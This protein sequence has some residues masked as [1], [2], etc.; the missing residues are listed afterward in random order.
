MSSDAIETLGNLARQVR[1]RADAATAQDVLVQVQAIAQDSTLTL[2]RRLGAAIENA[3]CALMPW[4]PGPAIADLFNQAERVF[5]GAPDTFVDDWFAHWHNLSALYEGYGLPEGREAMREQIAKVA[6]TW[7]GPLQ[8][9][10]AKV[11]IDEAKAHR[12]DGRIEP[13]R[14]CLAL[15]D[16]YCNGQDR[17]TSDRLEWLGWY[18]TML[19]GV[20]LRAEADAVLE[21]GVALSRHGGQ[22]QSEVEFLLRRV[23]C[24]TEQGD[25]PAAISL[26][27]VARQ[28]VARPPLAGTPLA[29]AVAIN[30]IG[31][32]LRQRDEARY[33]EALSQCTETIDAL[34]RQGRDDGDEL[35]YAH[36]YRA[37]LFDRL[38]D[39]PHAAKDYRAA[40]ATPGPA[41][42][43]ATEWLSLAGDAFFDCGDF[44]SASECYLDA[45]RRR[46]ALPAA[47]SA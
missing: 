20:E 30:W 2:S 32:V 43:D 34:H 9:L 16:R 29:I 31:L 33:S 11:L 14:V 44:N 7:Q 39:R 47:A 27:Q 46:A 38:G 28:C 41:A 15:A 21:Q 1:E 3:A 18:A 8:E 6:A 26:V 10:G 17:S 37:D 5:K 25:L 24:A 4:G 35:A 23:V 36:Y 40:A 12:R 45:V 13:M 22:P 42:T 19:S